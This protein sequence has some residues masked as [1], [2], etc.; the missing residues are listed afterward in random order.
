MVE[1]PEQ[2][3]RTRY[4]G[5]TVAFLLSAAV[6][7]SLLIIA[8]G[9][10]DEETEAAEVAELVETI[11]EESAAVT[12]RYLAAP[13][14]AAQVIAR[15]LAEERTI[16]TTELTSLLGTLT[17][18]H[19][20]V[21]GTFVGYPDGSF[22][23]VRRDGSTGGFRIKQIDVSPTGERAVLIIAADGRLNPITS[24]TDVEDQYD[25]RIRPWYQGIESDALFWTEPYIFFSSQEPGIT[26]SVAVRGDDGS[27]EA[28]I[29]VD[30]RL[31]DLDAFLAERVPSE[32][33]SAVVI[34]DSGQIIAGSSP[35]ATT[36]ADSS[37]AVATQQVG[38]TTGWTLVV[39]APEDDFLQ[40]V[41][42]SRR[43]YAIIATAVG[44]LSTM[45]FVSAAVWITKHIERLRRLARTD[46]LTGTLNRAT[47]RQELDKLL[48]RTDDRTHLA[49]MIL[50]LDDFK[51]INDQFG[52]EAGDAVL[53]TLANRLLEAA[54]PDALLGRLGGDE[55]LVVVQEGSDT[56]NV[57][58]QLERVIRDLGD[59]IAAG[60]FELDVNLSAGYSVV[61]PS[62]QKTSGEVLT[63]ADTALYD[64]KQVFSTK[65]LP[66]D[67]SM[68][69]R[70][71]QDFLRKSELRASI[72]SNQFKIHFQ[73]EVNLIT[74]EVV[75]A[76]ALMRWDNPE[77][78]LLAAG[79][80]IEDLERFDLISDLLGLLIERS[81]TFVRTVGK[82]PFTM[83]INL[84]AEQLIDPALIPLLTTAVGK[85][86]HVAWCLEVT[87]RSVVEASSIV[88]SSLRKI[89][90]LGVQVA[91]DD[92][93]TGYS[94]LQ[95][96]Q[97]LPVDAIK[98]D[99]TFV[100][101]LTDG[102]PRDSIAAI[103]VDLA[104]HM[105]VDVIAEGI[106]TEAQRDAVEAIGC[107]R[108]QGFHLGRPVPP[109][110]F[111]ASWSSQMPALVSAA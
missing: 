61:L 95:E 15:S 75:G 19:P 82:R 108:A 31:S 70:S 99:R 20:N 22:L 71:A 60:G 36:A 34:D 50:D 25:P 37:R 103:L 107:I 100:N 104:A 91:L 101:R 5:F 7:A 96:L 72:D 89:R 27:T 86:P 52:H 58:A 92:F 49:A 79:D 97:E 45:L 24:S 29:G 44:V 39:E 41:R 105:Q 93:G 35:T 21:V 90:K 98:I 78:G 54:G 11:A 3:Q 59:P 17:A 47:V 111:L 83:R 8:S 32:N 56:P 74:N 109:E 38:E 51:I 63:E 106:E 81:T 76:E 110:E 87:E 48:K 42:T 33:G 46:Q 13:E 68:K 102:D 10:T 30:V 64:A 6:I 73:P 88:V 62:D 28:V 85:T 66:F 14:S 16:P 53:T 9:L 69:M 1:R 40:D 23:D 55:F 43:R 80:F 77:E 2:D 67:E 12:D 65:L 57:E 26:H 4:L 84:S 18:T 94:S